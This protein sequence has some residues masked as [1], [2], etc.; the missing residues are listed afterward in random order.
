M[1]RDRLFMLFATFAGEEGDNGNDAKCG[2]SYALQTLTT[3][4]TAQLVLNLTQNFH[5]LFF[6][7]DAHSGVFLDST[8]PITTPPAPAL[9]IC[10]AFCPSGKKGGC[11]II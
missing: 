8:S 11:V 3:F 7:I 9:F 5:F 1:L 2:E 10:P 6:F 4:M